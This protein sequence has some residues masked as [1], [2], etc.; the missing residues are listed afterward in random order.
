MQSPIVIASNVP[1]QAWQSIADGAAA[2]SVLPVEAWQYGVLGVV[3][4]VFGLVIVRLFLINRTDLKEIAEKE[5]SWAVERER[6]QKEHELERANWRLEAQRQTSDYERKFKENSESNAMLVEE[7]RDRFL[8]REDALRKEF[9]DRMERVA[10]EANEAA[11]KIKEVLNK[12]Y[13]RFVGPRRG[14]TGG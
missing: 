12:V 2:T 9:A 8:A 1:T 5:K 7:I 4:C 14:R 3:A 6:V 10:N 11:D 13:D